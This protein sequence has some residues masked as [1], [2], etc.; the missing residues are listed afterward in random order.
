MT[1]HHNIW[2]QVP[3]LLP[4]SPLKTNIPHILI[5]YVL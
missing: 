1:L 4:L 2:I 5:R 3:G